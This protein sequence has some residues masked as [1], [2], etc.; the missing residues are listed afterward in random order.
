VHIPFLG[1]FKIFGAYSVVAKLLTPES[2]IRK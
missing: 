1:K 2:S